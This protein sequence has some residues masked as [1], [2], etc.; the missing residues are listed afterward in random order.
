M[1][2]IVYSKHGLPVSDFEALKTAEQVIEIYK[3]D[4]SDHDFYVF[5]NEIVIYS[6]C[7]MVKNRLISN[8]DILFYNIQSDPYL[9]KPI[10]VDVHGSLKSFPQG[11]C[12]I[13]NDI[14]TKLIY[15]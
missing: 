11:F 8:E 10:R 1:L 9:N 12:S 15:K 5:S 4:T 2:K 6:F 14:I 13:K 7:L 3:K